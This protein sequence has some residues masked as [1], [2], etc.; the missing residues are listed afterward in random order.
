MTDTLTLL[1]ILEGL[2]RPRVVIIGDLIIDRY[3]SGDVSRIRLLSS[4]K[5]RTRRSR[6]VHCCFNQVVSLRKSPARSSNRPR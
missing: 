5:T 4:C 2:G 6:R 1:S 3:I